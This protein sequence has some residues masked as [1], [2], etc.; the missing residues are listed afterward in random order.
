MMLADLAIILF[1][2]TAAD[3]ANAELAKSELATAPAVATAEPVAVYRPGRAAPPLADWLA[4]QPD[5]PRQRL[6]IM[7]RYARHDAEAAIAAGHEAFRAKP[8]RPAGPPA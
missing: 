7:V 4:T 8:K 1:M 2:I 6:T 5:D 3:L